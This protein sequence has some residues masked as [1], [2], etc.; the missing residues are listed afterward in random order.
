MSPINYLDENV[1]YL[2]DAYIDDGAFNSFFGSSVVEMAKF[3]LAVFVHMFSDEE[4]SEKALLDPFLA[5]EVSVE[6]RAWS[7]YISGANHLVETYPAIKEKAD[8]LVYK[9][10]LD[11]TETQTP[12]EYVAANKREWKELHELLTQ[13]KL[14]DS[15][16]LPYPEWS[17]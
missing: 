4:D 17:I 9:R 10:Y 3:Y 7:H 1:M 2:A 11:F 15:C 12:E 8:S 13:S 16:F 6:H 5:C 14:D